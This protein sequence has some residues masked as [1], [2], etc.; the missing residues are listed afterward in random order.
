MLLTRKQ[1]REG[2][3]L[4]PQQHPS[5][6]FKTNTKDRPR[7]RRYA[8]DI[9]IKKNPWTK[10]SS[11]ALRSVFGD[12]ALGAKALSLFQSALQPKTYIN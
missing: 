11:S 2:A 3:H 5:T 9:P 7:K 8:L 1:L 4:R 12:D 10:T 6:K